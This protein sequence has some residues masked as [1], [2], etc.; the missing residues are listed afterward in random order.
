[1]RSDAVYKENADLDPTFPSFTSLPRYSLESFV[2]AYGGSKKQPPYEWVNAPAK[3]PPPRQGV[4]GTPAASATAK[5]PTGVNSRVGYGNPADTAR[6]AREEHTSSSAPEIDVSH[7]APES[8]E[9][10][11]WMMANFAQGSTSGGWSSQEPGKPGQSLAAQPVSVPAGSTGKTG[12][13]TVR[14]FWC[15]ILQPCLTIL[16]LYGHYL[17]SCVFPGETSSI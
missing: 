3:A 5:T 13:T 6:E 9:S 7:E 12:T 11:Q 10:G 17:L 16:L 1:M 2:E 15:S 8:T 4:W 14:P